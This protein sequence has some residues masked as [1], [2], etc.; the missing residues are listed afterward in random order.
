MLLDHHAIS[1]IAP[2]WKLPD[3]RPIRRKGGYVLGN[4]KRN[5]F[6]DWNFV[7]L[8]NEGFIVAHVVDQLM[9]VVGEIQK[10]DKKQALPTVT[11]DEEGVH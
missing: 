5:A 8:S 4:K 11:K 1:D 9:A 7:K 6:V 3:V 10:P 2:I